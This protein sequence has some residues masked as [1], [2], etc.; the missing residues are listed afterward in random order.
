MGITGTD[1]AKE[2]SAMTLT[3]DNFAGA[4]V[5]LTAGY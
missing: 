4:A 1:V 3:G 5:L 2:A